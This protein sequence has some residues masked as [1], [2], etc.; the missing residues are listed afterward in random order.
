[1]PDTSE[2]TKG[3]LRMFPIIVGLKVPFGSQEP[4]FVEGKT[5][6]VDFLIMHAIVVEVDGTSHSKTSR[7]IKDEHR[8][9]AM[10]KMGLRILR[11]TDE[12]TFLSKMSATRILAEIEKLPLAVRVEAYMPAGSY[13]KTHPRTW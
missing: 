4:I 9:E 7:E 6:K 13:W 10:K 3:E 11:F 1:M 5:F 8:D 12:E 2:Y